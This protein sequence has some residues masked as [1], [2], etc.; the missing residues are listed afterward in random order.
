M[1]RRLETFSM[2]VLLVAVCGSPGRAQA[3]PTTILEIDIEN[4]VNYVDDVADVS[5]FATDPN[6][7]T[8]LPGQFKDRIT[9]GDIVAVNRQPAK[10]VAVYHFRQLILST[11]PA[12]GQAIADVV[13]TG[14]G[15][16]IF[17]IL[18]QDGTP[19]GTIT[20]EGL[21]VGSPPPGAPLPITQGNRAILGGTGA[22]LGVRGQS[23]NEVTAQSVNPR[24]ASMSEDPANRRSTAGGR[25]RRVFHSI[26][27]SRPEIS[28]TSGGPA[29]THSSDF[30]LVT[31][32]K[33]AAAGEILSLFATGLGSV[34]PNVGPGN[35]FPSSPPAEVNSPVEVTVNG[36]GA[37]VLAAVGSPGALDGYQV[38][39]RVPSDT[40]GGVAEIQVS[41]AWIAGT[42]VSINVQ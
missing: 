31:A 36:K 27:M 4:T 22:F 24:A 16:E 3:P 28:N 41:A 34:R 2:T 11:N 25:E 1:I 15:T 42:P 23:G 37:E 6:V 32:A 18:K 19:I 21:G 17:E 7:T 14:F 5:K 30:T 20:C 8:G 33:P 12:P 26:P 39:F 35:R 13:R 38:N 9:I 29:V 40:A 10:G